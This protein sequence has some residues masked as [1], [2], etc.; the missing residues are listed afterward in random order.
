M[1]QV[2]DSDGKVI[3]VTVIKADPV[4]LSAKEPKLKM[5]MRQSRLVLKKFLNIK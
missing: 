4:K 2:F 1:T 3:P 5:A